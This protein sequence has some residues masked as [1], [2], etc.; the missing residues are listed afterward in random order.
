MQDTRKIKEKILKLADI[1][2]RIDISHAKTK[3]IKIKEKKID[4]FTFE[5]LEDALQNIETTTKGKKTIR[6]FID[7]LRSK[8]DSIIKSKIKYV[9]IKFKPKDLSK[10]NEYIKSNKNI[11]SFRNFIISKLCEEFEIDMPKNFSINSKKQIKSP[12]ILIPAYI[13]NQIKDK[14]SK[15]NKKTIDDKGIKKIIREKIESII[16]K[17]D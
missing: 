3:G 17:I 8:G 5:E 9:N 16:K 11:R 7:F 13:I 6:G 10:L 15:K 14:V 2:M 4:R 1:Q 12:Q